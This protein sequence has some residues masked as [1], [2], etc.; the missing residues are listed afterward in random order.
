MNNL[1]NELRETKNRLLRTK[2]DA[3]A[4][5]T[6]DANKIAK[7]IIRKFDEKIANCENRLTKTVVKEHIYINMNTLK[8]T[9]NTLKEILVNDGFVV[10]IMKYTE[11]GN[12]VTYGDLMCI[13]IEIALFTN[14][15]THIDEFE[16]VH[17][18]KIADK[19]KKR[20]K[21]ALRRRT[22]I[23]K[24]NIKHT[25]EKLIKNTIDNIK[26]YPNYTRDKYLNELAFAK[27][28]AAYDITAFKLN[29]KLEKYVKEVCT[30]Y[31]IEFKEIEFTETEITIMAKIYL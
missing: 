24:K 20:I 27:N 3:F 10:N 15:I 26:R 19:N 17:L 1:I 4:N 5:I 23:F 31:E 25:V 6:N 22:V 16:M 11:K 21:S 2:A 9:V 14:H 29:K 18:E 28:E 7:E 13:T 12:F 30:E 8:E